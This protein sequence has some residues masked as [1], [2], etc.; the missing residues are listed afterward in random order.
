MSEKEHSC[1]AA[2]QRAHISL[3]MSWRRQ[4]L[5]L[6][7]IHCFQI[8]LVYCSESPSVDGIRVE[9]AALTCD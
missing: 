1:L 6:C 4:C 3:C 8:V 2:K 9:E 7:D 5:Y